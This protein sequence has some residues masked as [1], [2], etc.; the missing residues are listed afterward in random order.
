MTNLDISTR[1]LLELPRL[2]PCR[3][4]DNK[5]GPEGAKALAPALA[6]NAVLTSV[7][8]LDNKLDTDSATMLATIAKEKGI[9]LCGITPGQTEADF[10]RQNLTSV[11]AILLASDLFVR[12]SLT[13][14]NIANNKIGPEGMKPLCEALK[15]N[16]ALKVLDVNA[17]SFGGGEIGPEGAKYV[18]DM[19]LV[20]AS[21]TSVRTLA[22][23]PS[24]CLTLSLFR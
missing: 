7:T 12:A 9:S 13:S 5:L 3:L 23:K 15:V 18:A 19:L 4:S 6:A 21:L 11:D 8:L 17:S 2:P 10:S 14:L 24:R 16:K 22:H 20:N 1:H